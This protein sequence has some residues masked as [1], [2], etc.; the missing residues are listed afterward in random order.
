M[1][2]TTSNITTSS[3]SADS[4]GSQ[5]TVWSGL[6]AASAHLGD[7]IICPVC[8]SVFSGR[9]RQC[10]AGHSVCET[11]FDRLVGCPTCR[12]SFTGEMR[13]YALEE[14]IASLQKT[15]L[16]SDVSG[17]K[18]GMIHARNNITDNFR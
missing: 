5:P 11:C 9:I 14:V 6:S 10:R 3:G 4:L 13:N 12:G 1:P 18:A 8:L 7:A 17:N 16:A 2:N 15:A